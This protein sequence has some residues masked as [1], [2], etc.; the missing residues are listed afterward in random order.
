[1][2]MGRHITRVCAGVVGR[3]FSDLEGA[4]IPFL[5]NCGSVLRRGADARFW[6]H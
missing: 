1:M 6:T 2:S 4:G 3:F 5:I